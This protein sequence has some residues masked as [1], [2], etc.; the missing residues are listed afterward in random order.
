MNGD[1]REHNKV[2]PAKAPAGGTTFF[3]VTV[4][5]GEGGA[6]G[7]GVGFAVSSTADTIG[8]RRRG[9]AGDGVGLG[10]FSVCPITAE[11]TPKSPIAAKT[12]VFKTN[13]LLRNDK[14]YCPFAPVFGAGGKESK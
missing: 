1:W 10:L 7:R 14:R 5:R 6:L 4:T 2:P 12:A 3:M 11:P 13:L 8:F 9:T